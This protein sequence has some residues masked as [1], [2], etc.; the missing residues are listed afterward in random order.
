MPGTTMRL[1]RETAIPPRF[2]SE[3]AAVLA[4]LARWEA[5]TIGQALRPWAGS[6]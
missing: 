5:E 1:S 4:M 3:R 2:V 6:R